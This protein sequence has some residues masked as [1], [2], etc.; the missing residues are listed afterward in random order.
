MMSRYTFVLNYKRKDKRNNEVNQEVVIKRA[1]TNNHWFL[2]ADYVI[3][4]KEK[5]VIKNRYQLIDD[6]NVLLSYC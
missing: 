3:D 6:K 4:N 5:K 1:S 2:E